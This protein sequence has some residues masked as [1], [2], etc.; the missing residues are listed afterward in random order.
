MRRVAHDIFPECNTYCS[1]TNR[2]SA[3]QLVYSTQRC[4]YTYPGCP[5]L[6]CWHRSAI[7]NLKLFRTWSCSFESFRTAAASI[8]S[9]FFS[10]F[11]T[12]WPYFVAPLADV[13]SCA[14]C[15][16]VERVL[17]LRTSEE[18]TRRRHNSISSH[19]T[20]TRQPPSILFLDECGGFPN[21]GIRD[22]AKWRG[23]TAPGLP[24]TPIGRLAVGLL[25]R[26]IRGTAYSIR[27]DLPPN[28]CPRRLYNLHSSL[29]HMRVQSSSRAEHAVSTNIRS[30][31]KVLP[32][33][34]LL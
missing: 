16:F 22:S 20:T 30:R 6:N 1:H 7:N 9:S 11:M 3:L 31:E 26:A 29:F 18:K 15:M 32:S 10:P 8:F 5:P 17:G 4:R 23:T 25:S 2:A 27:K 14:R 12:F 28:L 34:T 24:Q 33:Y 13:V 19:L 21:W